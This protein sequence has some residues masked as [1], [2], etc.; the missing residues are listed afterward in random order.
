MGG[1]ISE[2]HG[3]DDPL[4]PS[5]DPGGQGSGN[6]PFDHHLT[7]GGQGSY[8]PLDLWGSDL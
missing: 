8:D 5:L 7:F 6:P 4:D 3:S 1:L 2:G